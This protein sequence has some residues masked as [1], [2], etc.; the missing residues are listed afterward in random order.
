MFINVPLYHIKYKQID[1]P[2]SVDSSL[3]INPNRER[4][5]FCIRYVKDDIMHKTCLKSNYQMSHF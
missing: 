1:F 2:V 3:E 4:Q 5:Y